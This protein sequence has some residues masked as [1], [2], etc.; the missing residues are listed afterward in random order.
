MC[1]KK[2]LARVEDV[3]K[4]L[5]SSFFYV[6]FF[7]KFSY[8]AGYAYLYVMSFHEKKKNENIREK[9]FSDDGKTLKGGS[10]LIFVII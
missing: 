1:T 6:N 8:Y 5:L 2:T 10:S 7:L 4:L 9:S 3:H